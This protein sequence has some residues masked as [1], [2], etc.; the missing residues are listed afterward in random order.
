MI[1]TQKKIIQ[2]AINR[3]FQESNLKT[4]DIE[5]AEWK[6][7][8]GSIGADLFD[9]IIDNPFATALLIDLDFSETLQKYENGLY[10]K[11][12]GAD[13]L[14]ITGI[15]NADGP[16]FT[17]PSHWFTD[18]DIVYIFGIARDSKQ[19]DIDEMNNALTYLK[20]KI[21]DADTNTFKLS[22]N[23]INKYLVAPLCY[24]SVYI[25]FERII[26]ELGDN[27]LKKILP[28]GMQ[29]AD[30][31]AVKEYREAFANIGDILLSKGIDYIRDL[32]LDDD[33]LTDADQSD[34]LS[35]PMLYGVKRRD[36][37]W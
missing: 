27:G 30:R 28:D 1:V 9:Y 35:K 37:H 16:T 21:K 10:V 22:S 2:T 4:T 32:D 8:R 19:K 34:L 13:E 6:H 18:D 15:N 20:F 5:A 24:Y 12:H 3:P 33:D 11:K 25:A 36:N 23:V 29:I 7:L 31:E 14:M 17:A 26:T